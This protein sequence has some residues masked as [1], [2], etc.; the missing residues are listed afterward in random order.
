MD[1][2]SARRILDENVR[3]STDKHTVLNNRTSAHALHY[4]ARLFYQF[5]VADFDHH[6]FFCRFALRHDF[7]DFHVVKLRRGALNRRQ[8]L[9]FAYSCLAFCGNSV[10]IAL[11]IP[12][13][14]AVNANLRVVANLS[15]SL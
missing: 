11:K 10:Q 13:V 7:D 2:I 14:F 6:T 9:R 3:D 8:N 12:F 5:F 15:D 4:T 1:G